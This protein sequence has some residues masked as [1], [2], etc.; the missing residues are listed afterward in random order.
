MN[1]KALYK[2]KKQLIK[3]MKLID[4]NSK[5]LLKKLGFSIKY[6]NAGNMYIWDD[7][8]DERMYTNTLSIAGLPYRCSE[9]KYFTLEFC[10]F[11]KK[12]TN[13]TL[14]NKKNGHTKT[15]KIEKTDN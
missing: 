4:D 10:L 14:Y 1:K 12:I 5:D 13:L 2:K 9:N 11:N 8:H 3:Q 6:D 15:L 7:M